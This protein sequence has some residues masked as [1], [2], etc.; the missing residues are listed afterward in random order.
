MI[1]GLL[2]LSLVDNSKFWL[3]DCPDLEFGLIPESDNS[4]SIGIAEEGVTCSGPT[5]G[6]CRTSEGPEGELEPEQ[7]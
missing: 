4:S 5:T 2:S 1:V 6:T 7:E 3:L